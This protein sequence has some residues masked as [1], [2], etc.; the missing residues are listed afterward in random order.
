V[1]EL[2]GAYRRRPYLMSEDEKDL[3]QRLGISARNLKVS[4]FDW[5]RKKNITE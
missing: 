2:E 4:C 5:F 3:V 1:W